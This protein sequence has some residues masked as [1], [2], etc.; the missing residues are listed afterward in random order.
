M[1]DRR[2]AARLT[3]L[4]KLDEMLRDGETVLLALE[5]SDG[6]NAKGDYLVETSAVPRRRH[7][8]GL[9]LSDAIIDAAKNP[10]FKV[11]GRPGCQAKG[12]PQPLANFGPDNDSRDGHGSECRVCAARRINAL[13]RKKQKAAT[14]TPQGTP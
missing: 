7:G 6:N 10:P 8:R 13:T 14:E 4:D 3:C 9:S 12:E 11:C 5:K 1:A 2:T